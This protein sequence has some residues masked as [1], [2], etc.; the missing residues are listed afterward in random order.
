VFCHV[1][2]LL[3]WSLLLVILDEFLGDHGSTACNLKIGTLY[4]VVARDERFP[5]VV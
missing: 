5:G 1:V 3:K 2:G 4:Q